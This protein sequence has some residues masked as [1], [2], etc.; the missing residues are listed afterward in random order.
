M[1]KLY[2]EEILLA[3]FL[4]VQV[5]LVCAGVLSRYFFGWSISFTE[6]ISRSLMVWLACL[7]FSACMGRREIIGFAWPWSKSPKAKTFFRYFNYLVNTAFFLILLYSSLQMARLQW[8]TGQKT[9][10]M[11]WPILWVSIALPLAC[12]LVLW[13]LYWPRKEEVDRG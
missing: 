4:I 6:E 1:R 11:G 7:G 3:A 5:A 13:R 2:F 12:V 10:V 8:E 9:S